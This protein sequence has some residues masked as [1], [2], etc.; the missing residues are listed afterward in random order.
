MVN[1]DALTAENGWQ[2]L[3][4]PANLD[5][6]RVLASIYLHRRRSTEVSQTL[7]YVWPSPGLVRLHYVYIFGALARFAR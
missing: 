6:F 4:S 5:G 7:H 3:G 1:F 2:V